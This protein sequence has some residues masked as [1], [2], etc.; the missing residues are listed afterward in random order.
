LEEEDH[1]ACNSLPY[2][3][4]RTHHGDYTVHFGGTFDLLGF[5]I[6]T[7]YIITVAPKKP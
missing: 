6:D 7:T 4:G 2:S 5:S 1:E 3:N